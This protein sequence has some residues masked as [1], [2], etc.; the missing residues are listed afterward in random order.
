M[1]ALWLWRRTISS[2]STAARSPTRRCARPARRSARRKR[3]RPDARLLVTGCAAQIEP[4][5]FAAH[6]GGEP[7]CSATPT[8]SMSAPFQLRVAERRSRVSDI[9]AVRETAPHLAAALPSARGRSSRCRTAATIAAPSA[10]SRM[11]AGP[12]ARCRPASVRRADQGAGRRG[13]QRGGADRRR[14]HQLRPRP[15]RRA[16]PGALVERILTH[17]PDLPRLRLS[18]LDWIEIDERLFEICRRRAA[19][20]CRTSICACSRATT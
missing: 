13:L 15:A 20:S 14:R 10:S 4:R 6:A 9:M 17:V 3:A 16:E 2:S 19:R 12:A 5:A 1:R 11:A 7:A 18:S 8:S